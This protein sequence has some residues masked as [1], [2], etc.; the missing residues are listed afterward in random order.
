M[1]FVA[2]LALLMAIVAVGVYAVKSTQYMIELE[3]RN[4]EL[5]RYLHEL[6]T[7]IKEK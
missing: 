1:Q 4:D 6:E 2:D 5:M 3:R 7:K